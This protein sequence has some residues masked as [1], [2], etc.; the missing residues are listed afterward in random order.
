MPELSNDAK[1]LL[2]SAT[3]LSGWINLVHTSGISGAYFYVRTQKPPAPAFAE[4]NVE[5][6]G[7]YCHWKSVLDELL[8][9]GM[10]RL[11]NKNASITN[12]TVTELGMV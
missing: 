1:K 11:G 3:E 7:A 10:I 4:G 8:T 9:N 6:S 12:Y 2:R 5:H